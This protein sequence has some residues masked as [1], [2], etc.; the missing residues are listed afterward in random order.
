ML[1]DPGEELGEQSAVDHHT[2]AQPLDLRPGDHLLPVDDD[3]PQRQRLR[4][5]D[6]RAGL[7]ERVHVLDDGR[8]PQGRGRRHQPVVDAPAQQLDVLADA[9]VQRLPLDRRGQHHRH[10][11]PAG[12]VQL[13]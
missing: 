4:R 10:L 13:A 12:R 3:Q 8:T 11:G 6:L 7:L 1:E 2:A 9:R 5:P